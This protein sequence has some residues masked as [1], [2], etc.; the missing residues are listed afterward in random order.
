MKLATSKRI[1]ALKPEG[2][3]TILTKATKLEAQ[4]KKIIHFEIGQPDFP[5][6]RH[7]T[8]AAIDA[9]KKG[10][11]KYNPPLGIMPL[12][13]KIA[14]EVS[15]SR[16][17]DISENQ[18]AITPSGKTAI[19]TAMAALL[20]KGDEVIYPDPG[21]P[22]YRTLT[23]FFGAIPKPVPLVEENNFSFDMKAFK[24]LFSRKTKLVILNS[25][26]NP[27]GGVI[28]RADLLEIA[29]IVKKTACW[30]ITD[31]IYA[32]IVYKDVP[33]SSY[34]GIRGIHDRTILVDGFSKT[35]SMTGWRIGYVSVPEQ[36]IQRIDN[37]LTHLVGCTA[38]FI[39]YAAL[40]GLQGS[41][42]PLVR[43]VKEFEKRRNFITCELNTIRGITCQQPAGA[44]YA[45]PN[46]KAFRKS[47]TWIANYLLEKAGVALLDGTAFGHYGEGYLRISYATNMANLKEGLSRISRALGK[48]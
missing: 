20:E 15:Q 3:Y 47:S 21:F 17:I 10:F 5:T 14:Q 40:E 30:I 39:Q 44:F 12:R 1:N 31:E 11:T 8:N 18:I 35:Y 16:N 2:A 22:T 37:L 38:T 23:E 25:P 7:I 26:S 29:D 36:I 41:K 9:L 33:Y 48:L 34:Y 43:M 28:P 19:F 4:G 24:R 32:K 46:I 13:K 27:T 45:F 42:E 6:P